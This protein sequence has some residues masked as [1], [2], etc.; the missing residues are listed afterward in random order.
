MTD[1]KSN[2]RG[3]RNA[4]GRGLEALLPKADKPTDSATGAFQLPLAHIIVNTHQPRT[5]FDET[6][7]KELAA[8]IRTYGLIQPITVRKLKANQ[9]QIISGERRFR[10][11][12][13]AGLAFIP[14]FVRQANDQDMLELALVENIQREELNALEIALSYQRLISECNLKQ[15]HLAT[16]VGKERSTITNYLRLLKLS[17]DIQAALKSNQIT[18]GHARSLLGIDNVA[19]QLVVLREI[20][21]KELSVREVESIARKR[22]VSK[23]NLSHSS[24]TRRK[25]HP[26]K[27]EE[28]KI[29]RHLGTQ[30]HI[31]AK[32][33]ESGEIRIPFHST[34]EFNRLRDLIVK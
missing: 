31:K 22:S 24:L 7:L 29:G 18:M 27:V 33:N 14:A 28:K 13:A 30:V 1:A 9:Y 25:A 8:S 32:K 21:E 23:N 2:A 11:A 10:G 20:I 12:K 4:L 15:E 19:H 6:S 34:E 26:Y 3:R 16:R 5:H 17:P